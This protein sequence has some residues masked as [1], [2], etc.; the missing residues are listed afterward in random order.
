M[1]S[2]NR[3]KNIFYL[4]RRGWKADGAGNWHSP[5]G[6]QCIGML[7]LF[8]PPDEFVRYIVSGEHTTTE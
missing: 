2:I 8:A 5:D 4:G 1:I 3:I 6:K 7:D